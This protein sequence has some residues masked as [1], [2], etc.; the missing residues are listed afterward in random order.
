MSSTAAWEACNNDSAGYQA[1]Y[2]GYLFCLAVGF[3]VIAVSV[4]GILGLQVFPVIAPMSFVINCVPQFCSLRC[5]VASQ[6]WDSAMFLGVGFG[7]N[8][9]ITQTETIFVFLLT[10]YGHR[11]SYGS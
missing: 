2:V 11:S 6:V 3:F 9:V 10:K 5:A 7:F 8:K 1:A 4:K